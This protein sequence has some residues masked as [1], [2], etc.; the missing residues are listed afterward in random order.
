METMPKPEDAGGHLILIPRIAGMEGTTRL[1]GKTNVALL[2]EWS[3]V[4]PSGK[5]F[6]VQTIEGEAQLKISR[7]KTLET[8]MQV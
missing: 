1:I 5:V 4:D 2:L 8:I 6:W 7:Q 3:A